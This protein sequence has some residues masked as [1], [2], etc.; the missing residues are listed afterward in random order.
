M[1]SLDQWLAYQAQVHPQAIDLGLERLRV[2]L[3]RLHWRPP[4]VPRMLM[5]L[6]RAQKKPKKKKK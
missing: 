4:T 5:K 3:E 2:V 1:R 6:R